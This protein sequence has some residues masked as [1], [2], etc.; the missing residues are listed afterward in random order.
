MKHRFDPTVYHTTLGSHAPVLRLADGDTL[1]TRTVDA[2]GV[3]YRGEQ[4]AGAPN[5]QTG[6]FYIEEA[7]PG[8][9]L[10]VYLERLEPNRTHGWSN[11]ALMPNVMDPAYV[12]EAP[13]RMLSD[14]HIDL[15]RGTAT[16]IT[17]E[18]H[19][20][21]WALPVR[22]M[23][24]CFGVAP[25]DGQAISAATSGQH[26]GNMDYRGFRPGV[27]AYF[28]IFMEGALF[29]LGDGH[30]LQA[31]GEILGAGIDIS[32]D[33]QVTF[34]VLKGWSIRWPR[35]EDERFI[36]TVGNARPLDQALQHATTEMLRWLQTDYGLDAYGAHILL[37]HTVVY[38]V[39]NVIDPAFTMVCKVPK[40]ALPARV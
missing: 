40:E 4:V 22:T 34:K 12:R 30:A 36:F 18:T 29:F 31:D 39:G 1:L 28:P 38:E 25:V 11:A 10:A 14:W 37:G 23:L 15:E 32:M 5:P 9:T 17:P 21:R 19:L 8:D 24:G 33:V 13:E 27:V 35:G 2:R 20:G 7:L 3:D 16:L 6:P 26:G